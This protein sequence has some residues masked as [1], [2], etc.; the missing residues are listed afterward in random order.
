M[1]K[2]EPE[3]MNDLEV[4]ELVLLAKSGDKDAFTKIY[5]LFY[6]PVYRFIFLQVRHKE[7]AEDLVQITFL[8][9]LE[10][11]N[12]FEE[13]GAKFSTWVYTI[14]R[15]S[16]IDHWKK[17]KDV[18]TS[19]ENFI[20]N[21]AHEGRLEDE[22][23]KNENAKMIKSLIEELSH[24]QKEIMILYFVEELSYREISNIIGKKED[25]IRALKY[26]ALKSL[27]GRIEGLKNKYEF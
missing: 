2:K 5:D 26:R 4:K 15:N 20:E 16:V 11:L 6:T 14:A 8:K 12:S 9:S 24:E 1:Y 22:I 27:R 10:A 18:I 3:K 17:K 23:Y 7:E 19:E 21:V 13:R 25:A